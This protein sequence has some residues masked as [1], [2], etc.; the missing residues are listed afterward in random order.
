MALS[1]RDVDRLTG[2][3][4]VPGFARADPMIV[5]RD[6]QEARRT[7]RR[8]EFGG[9]APAPEDPFWD[10]FCV[11]PSDVLEIDGPVRMRLVHHRNNDWTV[12]P[13][14]VSAEFHAA[15]LLSREITANFE[16]DEYE[17]AEAN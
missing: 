8:V 12:L 17:Q 11:L 16:D 15:E 1:V 9:P 3:L 2:L 4:F 5:P 10:L 13:W 7:L 14:A 6:F